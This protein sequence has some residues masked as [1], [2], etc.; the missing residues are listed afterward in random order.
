MQETKQLTLPVSG[1]TVVVR[2]YVTGRIDEEIKLIK[3]SANKSRF[4]KEID[5]N[6]VNTDDTSVMPEGAMKMIM[7]IDPSVQIKA[8]R[9]LLELM[10]VSVDE[11]TTDVINAVLDLPIDDVEYIRKEIK[12]IDT[13]SQVVG[14]GPKVPTV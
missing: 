6:M 2:G 8:D 12:A 9:R 7:D 11:N 14:S 1:K 10:V 3:A 13:A 4:E 5:A